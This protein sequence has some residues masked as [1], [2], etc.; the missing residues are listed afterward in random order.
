[1]IFNRPGV[2][3][4]VLQ[5]ALIKNQNSNPNDIHYYCVGIFHPYKHF[6]SDCK[7]VNLLIPIFTSVVK[8]GV[9]NAHFKKENAFL[10]QL[11]KIGVT[12]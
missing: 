4:A 8:D 11:V 7:F 3:G 10:T 2:S 6:K 12:K 5:T 1:M 9:E